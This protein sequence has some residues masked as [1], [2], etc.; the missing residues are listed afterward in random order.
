MVLYIVQS[1]DPT[2]PLTHKLTKLT[3]SGKRRVQIE[4]LTLSTSGP[5]PAF[6]HLRS[7]LSRLIREAPPLFLFHIDPNCS[8]YAHRAPL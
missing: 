5:L 4:L 8:G 7:I 6:L 3:Q 1:S 2:H